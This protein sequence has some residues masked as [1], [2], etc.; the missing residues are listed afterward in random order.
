MLHFKNVKISWIFGNLKASKHF[1]FS[2]FRRENWSKLSTIQDAAAPHVRFTTRPISTI[3]AWEKSPRFATLKSIRH[4]FTSMPSR[5]N[6]S[7]FANVRVAKRSPFLNWLAWQKIPQENLWLGRLWKILIWLNFLSGTGLKSLTWTHGNKALSTGPWK[8]SKKG[9][10]W[11]LD[12]LS[13]IA[14]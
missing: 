12:Y 9:W 4:D 1:I 10:N 13:I 6:T 11:S 5:K 14:L 2:I 7:G 8:R 3:Y